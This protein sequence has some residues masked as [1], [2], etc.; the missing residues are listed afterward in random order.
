MVPVS[1]HSLH[2]ERI[3]VYDPK[4]CEVN[5]KRAVHLTNK[6]EQV[7][8]NGDVNVLEGERFVA[9]CQF[10]P[11]IPGDDQLI[12]LGPDTTLSVT[13]SK[14][15]EG[16]HDRVVSVEL[17]RETQGEHKGLLKGCVLNHVQTVTT[18][19]NI[20]NNGT[21]RVPTLYVEHT[22]RMD[23]GG[24]VI[25]STKHQ[26]KQVTGWARYCLAVEPET[27]V[28]LEVVEEASYQES[29]P[30]SSSASFLATRAA[31]LQEQ[32]VIGSDV[33]E[34]LRQMQERLHLTSMLE[35]LAR[36]TPVTEEKLLS[37]EGK[38]WTPCGVSDEVVSLLK[39]VRDL[40][41]MESEKAELKRKINVDTSRIQ[42]IF[43]NQERL[44]ENITAMENVRTGTLME[45]YMNDMDKEESD[46]IETRARIEQAEEEEARMEQA[47]SKL[48]LQITMAAKQMKKTCPA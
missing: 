33:L 11:M 39:K 4:T 27:E 18:R 22:A 3:L 46:L 36:S 38:D 41:G 16:Q 15:S 43:K 19:Y 40:K 20:M 13:R 7:F 26:V 5:V 47:R 44:R 48:A 14:P 31:A 8:A 29:V 9:Q 35:E 1:A 45:R 28:S 23:R 6:T 25:K 17:T 12:E 24:F 42:K 10:T 21:K 34:A 32:G 37:W 2:A 30:S